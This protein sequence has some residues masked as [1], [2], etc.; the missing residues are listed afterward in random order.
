MPPIAQ[1]QCEGAPEGGGGGIVRHYQ[2]MP[3][4]LPPGAQCCV[5]GAEE[6]AGREPTFLCVILAPSTCCPLLSLCIRVTGGRCDGEYGYA[7]STIT[8]PF[9]V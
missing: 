8:L 3:G 5:P 1:A 9:P 7:Q 4:A 2:P 6:G